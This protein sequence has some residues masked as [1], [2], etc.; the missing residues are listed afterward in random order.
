MVRSHVRHI[1]KMLQVRFGDMHARLSSYLP[2]LHSFSFRASAL[3]SCHPDACPYPFGLFLSFSKPR[4]CSDL[5]SAPISSPQAVGYNAVEVDDWEE[6]SHSHRESSGSTAS[7][8]REMAA[9]G[10]DGSSTGGRRST[11]DSGS[12]GVRAGGGSDAMGRLEA[13]LLEKNRKMEHELTRTK[14]RRRHGMR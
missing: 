11:Q 9:G 12:A 14:V 10:G 7:G 8:T 4:M 13:L 2:L 5:P 1:A 3:A 6:D